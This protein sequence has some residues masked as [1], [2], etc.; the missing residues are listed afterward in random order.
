MT[1]RGQFPSFQGSFNFPFCLLVPRDSREKEELLL[2]RRKSKT[3]RKFFRRQKSSLHKAHC[4][5]IVGLLF[6]SGICE[7]CAHLI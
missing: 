6:R 1:K 5:K 7:Q 4:N 2:G 3:E